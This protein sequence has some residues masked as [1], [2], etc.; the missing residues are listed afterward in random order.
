[1]LIFMNMHNHTKE[2]HFLLTTILSFMIWGIGATNANAENNPLHAVLEGQASSSNTRTPLWHNA[3]KYGLSTLNKTYAYAR[4]NV[5]Y[6]KDTLLKYFS[7][8]MGADMVL[9][10]HFYQQGYKEVHTSRLIIQQ[11]YSDLHWKGIGICLGFRQY[12]AQLRNNLLSSGAQTLGI[13]ARPIPQGRIYRDT[14]WEIP[15]LR[16]WVGF[17]GHIAYGITTDAEWQETFARGTNLPYNRWSRHH[18][19][20]GYLRIGNESRFPL[21]M[22]LGLEMASQFGGTLYNYKGA[23]QNGYRGYHYLKLKSD[24]L[25]YWHAFVSGGGDTDEKKYQNSEGNQ[26][27]SRLIRLD[28]KRPEYAIGVYMD[29]FFEDHSGLF[30]I[31]F[32]GYGT[33]DEWKEKKEFKYLH[34]PM[35]D[36]Q[37]GID[38]ELKYFHPI[39]GI[40]IEYMNTTYQSGPIYHDHNEGNPDHVG[41]IDDYYNHSTLPGWQHWGQAIGNPLYRSPQYNTDGYIYFEANRYRAW[42]GGING[43]F[44]NNLSYRVLYTWQKAFGTYAMPFAQPKE[45]QSL[46]LELTYHLPNFMQF[47]KPLIRLSYASD[48]GTLLGN[49][50]GFQFTLQYKL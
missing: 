33:G 8:K 28:W 11:L 6:D 31:D 46:L 49:N 5:E 29:H 1:M 48:K 25:S 18:E 41:G 19:K 24:L 45:N 21:T 7:L 10:F 50:S 34:Y 17:K 2:Y 38:L 16:K 23:D 37:L 35:K 39:Q 32:D 30:S 13:N 27:G 12:P 42:H 14:W 40:V 47:Q 44:S 36:F 3:N 4:V 22:T 15:G 9:P 43:E 20:A 26:L